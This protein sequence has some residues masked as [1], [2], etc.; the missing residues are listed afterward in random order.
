MAVRA[1][2]HIRVEV[3]IG[4][5][6]VVFLFPGWKDE[7]LQKAIRRLVTGRQEI[8]RNQ[9]KDVSQEARIAFFDSMA[10]DV[11]NYEDQDAAGI[12][13][14]VRAATHPGWKDLIPASWKTSCASFFEERNVLQQEDVKN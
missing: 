10:L 14:P 12:W 1:T 9:V 8:K 5:E 13:V 11:E 7:K 3:P 4:D 2:E 6:E